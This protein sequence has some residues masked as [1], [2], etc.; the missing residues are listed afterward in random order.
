M[1]LA[2]CAQGD[3]LNAQVDPRFG[4]CQ[5]FVLMDTETGEI[6]SLENPAREAPGGAGSRA[7]TC[8]SDEG[9]EAVLLGN[10]GPNGARVLEAAGIR[11]YAGSRGTVKE[12]IDLHLQGLLEEVTGQNVES[13]FDPGT[14]DQND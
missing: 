8:L 14:G 6:S 5:V 2:V 3:G 7:A 1:R 11:V 10:L 13:G 4:R 12:T 9:V